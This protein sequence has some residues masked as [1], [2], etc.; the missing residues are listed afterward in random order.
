MKHTDTIS[1]S[2]TD[3]VAPSEADMAQRLQSSDQTQPQQKTAKT[4]TDSYVS[5][6]TRGMET[7]ADENL[8]KS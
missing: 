7:P 2:M 8:A 6:L 5:A 1:G 3:K 4:T